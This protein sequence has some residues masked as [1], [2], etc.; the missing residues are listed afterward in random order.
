MPNLPRHAR[1]P[2]SHKQLLPA[3][4]RGLL[5]Q[6]Q[7]SY[8]L[9]AERCCLS[10]KSVQLVLVTACNAGFAGSRSGALIAT[11]WTSLVHMGEQGFM[12]ITQQLMQVAPHDCT[13]SLHA[14]CSLP[15][16]SVVCEFPTV[17]AGA[18]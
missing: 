13:T 14:T 10:S 5:F 2:L 9:C 1:H 18:A 15:A 6:M 11:A 8:G 16:L 7:H 17:G 4:T 3:F 12:H